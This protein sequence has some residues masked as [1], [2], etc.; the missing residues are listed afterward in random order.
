MKDIENEC[1]S[2]TGGP[3]RIP[4]YVC[5]VEGNQLTFKCPYC[6]RKHIHGFV[7]LSPGKK[8]HRQAHCSTLAGIEAH[9]QGYF[10]E[11]E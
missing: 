3:N 10:I 8:G 4:T 6:K 11:Y 5:A 9:A 2:V 1:D 7:R